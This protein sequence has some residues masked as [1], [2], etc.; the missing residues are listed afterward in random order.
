MK[1]NHYQ[2]LVEMMEEMEKRDGRAAF[3][4]KADFVR[5]AKVS[6]ST[7]YRVLES[8]VNSMLLF[9][10][11]TTKGTFT[12]NH[13]I[14][15]D[16]FLKMG[17]MLPSSHRKLVRGMIMLGMISGQENDYILPEIYQSHVREIYENWRAK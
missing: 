10:I 11:Q 3:L 9:R 8:A 4:T 15:S 13:Y 1:E 14:K 17:G 7:A 5:K 16:T 6:N 2:T 12:T